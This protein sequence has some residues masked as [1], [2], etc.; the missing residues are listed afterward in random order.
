MGTLFLAFIVAVIV[1]FIIQAIIKNYAPQSESVIIKHLADNPVLYFIY[2]I[3][4]LIIVNYF[5]EV[6]PM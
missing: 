3:I 6:I 1:Y 4:I 5:L 2:Y